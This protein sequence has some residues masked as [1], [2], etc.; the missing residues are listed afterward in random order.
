MAHVEDGEKEEEKEELEEWLGED[1]GGGERRMKEEEEKNSGRWR[2]RGGKRLG[3]R[4]RKRRTGE[5]GRRLRTVSADAADGINDGGIVDVLLI[6]GLW[7]EAAE[8]LADRVWISL[9]QPRSALTS[10]D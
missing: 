3:R 4:M 1:M 8:H 9:D 2:R 10:L 7:A 5:K 6:A